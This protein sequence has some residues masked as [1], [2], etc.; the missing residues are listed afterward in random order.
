MIS[1]LRASYEILYVSR[2]CW[3]SRSMKWFPAQ[4]LD[5]VFQTLG[6]LAVYM[7]RL[8]ATEGLESRSISSSGPLQAS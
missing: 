4:F 3:T 2:L 8:L 1:K 5:F 6:S 7:P